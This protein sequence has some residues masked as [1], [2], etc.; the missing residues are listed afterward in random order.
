MLFRHLFSSYMYVEKAAKTTF[1]QKIVRKM[2]IKLTQMDQI[3]VLKEG[4]IS[5]IGT[6]DEL[7]SFE[8]NHRLTKP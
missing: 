6:Y 2:L 7:V 3:V 8:N 4:K 1:V 5:E